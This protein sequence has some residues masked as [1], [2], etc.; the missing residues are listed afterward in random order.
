M[1]GYSQQSARGAGVDR[2]AALFGVLTLLLLGVAAFIWLQADPP[3]TAEKPTAPLI[4]AAPTPFKA[5]Y[6]GPQNAPEP[7]ADRAMYDAMTPPSAAKSAPKSA[8][9]QPTATVPIPAKTNPAPAATAA[10]PATAPKSAA[11]PAFASTGAFAAQLGAYSTPAA[12]RDA[13][14][15]ISRQHSSL[16]RAANLDLQRHQGDDGQ[17][18]HRLRVGYFQDRAQSDT[19]CQSMRAAGQACLVTP[20]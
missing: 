4:A 20:R 7:P 2:V 3:Q 6:D 11:A 10:E 16:M 13:F 5:P 19:F 17:V 12:A 18:L 9:P 1:N 14:A 8:P 15:A